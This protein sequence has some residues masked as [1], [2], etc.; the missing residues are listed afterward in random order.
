MTAGSGAV[1]HFGTPDRGKDAASRPARGRICVHRD[2]AT[3]LST[4]NVGDACW[5]H[6]APVLRPKPKPG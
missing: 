2:C 4:Y 5:L 3:V 6:T 1:T